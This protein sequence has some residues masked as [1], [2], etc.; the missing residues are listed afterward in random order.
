MTKKEVEVIFIQLDP[1]THRNN[2]EVDIS[3]NSDYDEESRHLDDFIQTKMKA[4]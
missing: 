4:I 2:Y 1:L 3:K